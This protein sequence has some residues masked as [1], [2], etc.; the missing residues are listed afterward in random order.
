MSSKKDSLE[1]LNYLLGN[2]GIDILLAIDRGA[3]DIETIKLFSGLPIACI[4]GRIPVLLDLNLI[5]KNN[6][7][8]YIAEKG[9]NFKKYLR[10]HLDNNKKS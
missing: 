1:D 4:R 6:Q 5:E 7:E 9:K 10:E 8:Y 3:K 2:M